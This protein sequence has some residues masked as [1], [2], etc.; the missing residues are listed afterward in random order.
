MKFVNHMVD[1]SFKIGTAYMKFSQ[2]YAWRV[3]IVSA[4]FVVVF[5]NSRP[6]CLT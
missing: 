1:F 4:G 2:F 3:Q 6:K 5:S